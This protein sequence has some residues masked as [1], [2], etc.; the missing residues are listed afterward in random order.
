MTT[1]EQ[2]Q[3]MVKLSSEGLSYAAISAQLGCSKWTVRKWVRAYKKK[4]F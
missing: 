2:R 4:E 3:K 1:L